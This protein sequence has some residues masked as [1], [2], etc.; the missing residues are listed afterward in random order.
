MED[1]T[2]NE[3]VPKVPSRTAPPPPGPR[4]RVGSGDPLLTNPKP[5]RH[6]R[7]S[8]RKHAAP[9]THVIPSREPRNPRRPPNPSRPDVADRCAPAGAHQAPTP[10]HRQPVRAA[11]RHGSACRQRSTSPAPHQSHRRTRARNETPRSP[12]A[13]PHPSNP[14]QAARLLPARTAK[15][16]QQIPKLQIVSPATHSPAP[17]ALQSHP[18]PQ[19]RRAGSLHRRRRPTPPNPTCG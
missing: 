14:H 5:R 17:R 9:T 4:K 7:P 6:P 3:P 18:T 19:A 13:N 12:L 15:Q 8:R 1:A 10:P 2:A 16:A 11:T